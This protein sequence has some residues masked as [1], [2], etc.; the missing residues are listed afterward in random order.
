M[1]NDYTGD[2]AHA[3]G[4]S[5]R[6]IST[7]A[8]RTLVRELDSSR[9]KRSD[10]GKTVFDSHEKRM[11][12]YTPLD[13]FK[14]KTRHDNPTRHYRDAPL[15]T[16]FEQL[17]EAEQ[18]PYAQGAEELRQIAAASGNELGR[19]LRETNGRISWVMLA[20][21]LAGNGPVVANKATVMNWVMSLPGSKYESTRILP[22]LLRFALGL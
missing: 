13:Y 7:S 17:S 16:E 19:I 1:R 18:L 9:K 6:T 15:R 10:G 12:V 2:H 4:M 21:K 11:Q 5:K 14:R 22:Q 3:W 8:K 20:K